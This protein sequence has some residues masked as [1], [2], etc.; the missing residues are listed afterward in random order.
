VFTSSIS[1]LSSA[2]VQLWYLLLGIRS[3]LLRYNCLYTFQFPHFKIIKIKPVQIFENWNR[4]ER[5]T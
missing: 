1:S 4:R 5:K 2:L 3:D